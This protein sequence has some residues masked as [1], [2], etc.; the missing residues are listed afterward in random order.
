MELDFIKD[1][2][3][4]KDDIL[5]SIDQQKKLLEDDNNEK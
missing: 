3:K 2:L 1:E 4:E 5:R